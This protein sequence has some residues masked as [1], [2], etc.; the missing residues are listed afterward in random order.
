MPEEF[1]T[2]DEARRLVDSYWEAERP[3]IST[4]QLLDSGAIPRLKGY[5]V[6]N[7]KVSDSIHGGKGVH[8]DGTEFENPP[9]D[10]SDGTPIRI[11]VRTQRVSTHDIQRGEIPFKDQ[12]LASNHNFM[13]RMLIDILGTSQYDVGLPD[14]SIVIAAENLEQIPFENVLREYMARTDTSTS[15]YV[16]YMNGEREFCGH[17]L[18]DDLF[19]NCKL[20]YVMDT[21]STK[22]EDHDE[23]VSPKRLFE[24]GVCTPEQYDQIRNSSLL[25]FSM[26]HQF[27]YPIGLIPVDTKTEH[28][29][30]RQGKIVGQDEFWTMDSSRFW[31]RDDYDHKLGLFTA[32]RD[33]E[34]L[35]YLK[36]TQQS[37]KEKD[38]LW[39]DRVAMTP[40][41]LSKEFARGF[42]KGEHGYTP[43]Q[44]KQIAVRYI[45]GVQYLLGKRFEPD[46][47]PHEERVVTGI[48]IVLDSL[49]V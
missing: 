14:N 27:L 40:R 15:L 47:R 31:Q 45:E 29:K 39:N 19:P 21:P 17:A 32:G 13:R 41:S 9:L 8:K 43:D 3:I 23:S 5:V 28:G 2:Q 44:A 10:A 25:A 26:V 7:G 11:M 48:R 36:E 1:L 18:P 37:I 42:S 6:R 33:D 46:M 4:Q 38:Y 30:N 12:I 49:V 20:P 22:S 16:H 35:T 34:L 24:L